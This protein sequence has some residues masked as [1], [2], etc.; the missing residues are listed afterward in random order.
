MIG[1]RSRIGFVLLVSLLLTGLRPAAAQQPRTRTLSYDPDRKTW[2]EEPPPAP[3]TAAGDLHAVRLRVKEGKYR[4][5]ESAVKKFVKQYGQSDPL[6]G[7]AMIAK[8]EALAGRREYYKA[9]VTI[10]ALLAE[11]D[12]AALIS[13]ALRLEF[14]IAEAYLAGAKR[15]LWG[16]PLLSGEDVAYRILDDITTDHRDSRLAELAIKAKA[17]HMFRKGDHELAEVEYA[18]LMR[19]HTQSRYY[20]LALRRS[21]EAALA[22][23]SGVD[24]DQAALVEAADRYSEYRVRFPMR[25][26]RAGVGPILDGIRE[27]HAEK[28]YSIGAY[29]ERTGHFGSAVFYYHWVREHWPETVA[30]T[31]AATRLLLL[32]ALQPAASGGSLGGA[33]DPKDGLERGDG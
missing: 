29:Y 21:A 22:G 26:E 32:G 20:P 15:K 4:A 18:R 2:V 14:V 25:A 8:A 12:D 1:L 24:Y 6:Y 23:F 30:A 19:E 31:K 10:E 7:E 33:A 9:Y 3:G 11:F 27:T 28:E 13:E 5:A 17:E 16:I